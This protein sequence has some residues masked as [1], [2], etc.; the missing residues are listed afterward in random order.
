MLNPLILYT[1]A[2]K[3]TAPNPRLL[4]S[5]SQQGSNVSNPLADPL[6]DLPT[7]RGGVLYI[8]DKPDGGDC[9]LYLL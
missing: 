9:E 6:G 8:A 1:L 4:W 5:A 2:I 7:L 3:S